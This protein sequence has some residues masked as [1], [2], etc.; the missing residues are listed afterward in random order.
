M[1]GRLARWC[2]IHPYIPETRKPPLF[3]ATRSHLLVAAAAAAAEASAAAPVLLPGG[4]RGLERRPPFPRGGGPLLLAASASCPCPPPVSWPRPSSA[5][6]AASLR[7]S[8]CPCRWCRPLRLGRGDRRGGRWRGGWTINYIQNHT[9]YKKMVGGVDP[10]AGLGHVWGGD[11]H[12]SSV[13]CS[14]MCLHRLLVASTLHSF[15]L[16]AANPTFGSVAQPAWGNLLM[17]TF[18]N[19]SLLCAEQSSR[20]FASTTP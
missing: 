14:H 7:S 17:A 11:R 3:V 5:F 1:R 20:F 12:R 16:L 13:R 19:L 2:Y 4:P 10:I 8:A 9:R 18:I 6:A 15:S